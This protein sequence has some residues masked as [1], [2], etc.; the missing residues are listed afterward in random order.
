M[1]S[2]TL[3]VVRGSCGIGPKIRALRAKRNSVWCS[4]VSTWGLLSK[5]ERG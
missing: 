1:L 2:E 4:S 3:A 5:I